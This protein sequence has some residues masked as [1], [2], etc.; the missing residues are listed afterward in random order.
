MIRIVAGA[1]R[2]R[3][4]TVP[5]SRN[6]RPTSDRV[7]EALFSLLGW[8]SGYR[9]VLDLYA[10]TGALGLEALSR[11][12][13]EAWFVENSRSSL[14]ALRRNI[15]ELGTEERCRVV[16]MDALRFT[17]FPPEGRF[18]LVFLDP[19]Y[20]RG[21]ARRTVE[22]LAAWSGLSREAVVVVEM[23]IREE[24]L[25]LPEKWTLIKE[26]GYGDTLVLIL[27]APAGTDQAGEENRSEE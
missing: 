10:G 7:R 14:R 22:G 21:L 6:T 4:L 3:R 11:G 13:G 18:D 24:R 27:R 16:P 1:Y 5:R 12:A 9:R 23:S 8:C 17:L 15:R 19:P 25:P 20:G 2:G 26:R